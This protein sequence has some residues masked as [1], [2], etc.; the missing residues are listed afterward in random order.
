[1]FTDGQT[2]DEQLVFRRA[3][4]NLG[5]REVKKKPLSTRRKNN[6]FKFQSCLSTIDSDI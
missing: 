6:D 3:H 2:D 4:L 1:M 5:F